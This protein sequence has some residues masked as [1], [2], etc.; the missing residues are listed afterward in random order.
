MKWDKVP[1]F[2]PLHEQAHAVAIIQDYKA[3]KQGEVP[4]YKFYPY[5]IFI[6]HRSI[7]NGAQTL[8]SL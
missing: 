3:E 6:H 5:G 7:E 1:I 4:K 2:F 8:A